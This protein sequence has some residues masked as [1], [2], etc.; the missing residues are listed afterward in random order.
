MQRSKKS[1]RQISFAGGNSHFES[2]S[3]SGDGV[4]GANRLQRGEQKRAA[5]YYLLCEP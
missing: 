5:F 4:V 3:G 2:A 1:R